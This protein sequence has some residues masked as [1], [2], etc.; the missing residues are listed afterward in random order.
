MNR[1]QNYTMPPNKGQSTAKIT[2]ALLALLALLA[3]AGCTAAPRT[4][5]IG[6]VAPFEGL[7]RPLGYQALFGVKL[8]VQEWN[9]RGGINGYR[10]ELVALNDFDDPAEA[11]VQAHSLL[12]DP[13]VLGVVGHLSAHATAAAA[14]FYQQGGL[15]LAAPWPAPPEI[16]AG[17]GVVG[18]AA[19]SAQ[20]EARLAHVIRQNAGGPAVVVSGPTLPVFN[21]PPLALHLTGDGVN[22]GQTLLALA[23]QNINAP[24]FAGVDAGSPQ[25]VQVAHQAANGLVVVSPGPAPAD[26]DA[27]AFSATYQALAGFPPGPRA[28]LA[29]DAAHVLLKAIET[30]MLTHNAPPARTAVSA[31]IAGV[32][33]HGL[34]GPISFDAQGQRL[35]PPVWVYRIGDEQYP[36]QLLAAP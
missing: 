31:A 12:A 34:T 36:G 11:A 22:A 14:P 6:L 17:G 5:K 18:I 13:D 19:T 23:S 16:F 25:V 29:Y 4:L 32:Q 26:I 7:H 33:H 1:R 9:A 30:A 20:T 35:N 15:A 24:R 2:G 10:I 21:P 3:L 8:A 28:V 27:A